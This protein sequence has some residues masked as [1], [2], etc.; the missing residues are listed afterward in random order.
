MTTE[1]QLKIQAALAKVRGQDSLLKLLLNDAL[2]WPVGEAQSVDDV[3]YSWSAEDLRASGL[4]QK[5]VDSRIWQ[6]QPLTKGQ[7]WGIFVLQF[8]HPDA[9]T[10]G[11]GM[12][13]VLRQVLRGLVAARTKSAS[14]ASW[15]REDLLF[16]CT[17][18]WQH[19]AFVHFAQPAEKGR[20]ARLTSFGWSPD[21]PNR[22]LIQENLPH[23]EWPDD[24][25]DSGLL[26]LPS[27]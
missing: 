17:H 8:K 19:Y 4:A 5:V 6:V 22:T 14:L 24:P 25:E 12:T 15:Q 10:T 13:G 21:S 2:G 27:A 20:A 18:A 3:S 9:F 16:I 1:L 11:R 7:P 26:E 23:L